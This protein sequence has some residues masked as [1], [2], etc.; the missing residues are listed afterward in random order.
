VPGF[1]EERY[2]TRVG[3]AV[4]YHSVFHSSSGRWEDFL[5]N[6]FWI[7][8]LPGVLLVGVAIVGGMLL[9]RLAGESVARLRYEERRDMLI[10]WL[11]WIIAVGGPIAAFV[12]IV[13]AGHY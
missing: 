11:F 2:V 5:N 1:H 4:Y 6:H 12:F 8:T 13:E 9:N 3:D 7:G 10:R